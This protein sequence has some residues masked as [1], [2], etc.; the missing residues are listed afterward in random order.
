MKLLARK[1]LLLALL[2]LAQPAWCFFPTN[3]NDFLIADIEVIV[4]G[5]GTVDLIP[6]LI[7]PDGYT[8]MG[9]SVTGATSSSNPYLFPPIAIINPELGTYWMGVQILNPRGSSFPTV[10]LVEGDNRLNSIDFTVLSYTYESQ[11]VNAVNCI[12]S[13]DTQL[14]IP[15]VYNPAN[16]PP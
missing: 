2:G 3:V 9:Q 7:Q 15:V 1:W 12:S 8:V 13:A 6:I 14:I 4:S 10:T 16:Y 5:T 11:P